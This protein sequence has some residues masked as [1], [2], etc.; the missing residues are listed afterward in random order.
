M[1][2]REVEKLGIVPK[3]NPLVSNQ[4]RSCAI[5]RNMEARKRMKFILDILN[6]FEDSEEDNIQW[7][8]SGIWK[9]R[10]WTCFQ[11]ETNTPLGEI[12]Q[13]RINRVAGGLGARS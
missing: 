7:A 4:E 3:F 6:H 10:F 12:N 9:L 5:N 11:N 1:G 13:K 8:I 2:V